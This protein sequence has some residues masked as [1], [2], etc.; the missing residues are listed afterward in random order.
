MITTVIFDGEVLRPDKPLDLERDRRYTITI[1]PTKPETDEDGDAWDVLESLIG[2]VEMP[3]DWSVERDRYLYGTPK[4][5][6]KENW[7]DA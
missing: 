7:V 4:R 2:T 3:P 6:S 1:N 5:Y